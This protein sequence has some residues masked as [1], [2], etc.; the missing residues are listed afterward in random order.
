[1][2]DQDVV[3]HV[4]VEIKKIIDRYFDAATLRPE[5]TIDRLVEILDRPDVAA[6][7]DRLEHG[8]GRARLVE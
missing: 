3:L 8:F 5:I 4:I 1:M 7:I 2:R 6:A